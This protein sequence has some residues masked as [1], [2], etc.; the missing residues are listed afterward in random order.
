MRRH[1]LLIT[2]FLGLIAAGARAAELGHLLH[3]LEAFQ[4]QAPSTAT[5]TL[6]TAEAQRESLAQLQQE[7]ESEGEKLQR[8]LREMGAVQAQ[9]AQARGTMQQSLQSLAG[10]RLLSQV[11]LNLRRELPAIPVAEGLPE[12]LAE[13]RIQQ[14]RL[15]G[16][17]RTL[18]SA[19]VAGSA[20]ALPI[21]PLTRVLGLLEQLIE[22]GN[23]LQTRQ[24]ALSREREQLKRSLEEQLFWVPSHR[25]MDLQWLA[26]MPG[27]IGEQLA[28]TPWLETGGE[29]L[30]GLQAR[31]QLF[32]PLMLIIATLLWRR[33]W[34]IAQ[35]D[36]LNRQV[37]DP[38]RDRFWTTPLAVILVLLQA[39][40]VALALA[41]CGLALAFDARGENPSLGAA[42]LAMAEV[43]L[44][45]YATLRVL[46]PEGLAERHFHWP[47]ARVSQLRRQ[48]RVLG[49]VVLA[50]A[51]ITAFARNRPNTLEDDALG[52][53]L[54]SAAFLLTAW[55]LFRLTWSA[56][57]RRQSWS[58]G[59]LLLMLLLISMPLAL[60]LTVATGYYYTA[61]KLTERLIDSLLLLLLWQLVLA[62]MTRV[63]EV[64]AQQLALRRARRHA[65]A[66]GGET[67]DEAE[68]ALEVGEASEQSLRL[69][70]T[71]LLG[72][73][74]G[75]LYWVWA[76]L[77]GVISY[78]D[79]ITLWQLAATEETGPL[80]ISL[81]DFL[82]ALLI[83]AVAVLLGRNLPGLLEVLVLS[84]LQLAPGSA[85]AAT[86][87]LSYVIFS[88]GLIVAL[89]TLGVSWDK[90][91]WLVAALGVGLGF[92]LQEIFANF[93]SGLILLFE[94]P[95]R[96]GDVV[97]LGTQ[98]GVVKKIRIRATTISDFDRKDIIIPNKV[99]ITGDLTNW[100]L[101]DTII[102]VVVKVGV[103]YGSDLDLVRKLLLEIAREHPRVL[104]EPAPQAY[105]L[106]FGASTLDHEL[107]MHVPELD[108]RFAVI[109]AVNRRI[110]SV[111]REH[112][113]E[114]AFNQ[115]DLHL[116][117]LG[118]DE[119]RIAMRGRTGDA[120]AP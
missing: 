91:Q 70:Q 38:L 12:Q 79:N 114:I 4:Q 97:T 2:L 20:Q 107:R 39:L 109:D 6:A 21:Q 46:R 98:T 44:I 52:V 68:P 89:G 5:E 83:L 112:G 101:T 75:A 111:F 54:L 13:L 34:L 7:L 88:L 30:A 29:I 104:G 99:F 96:I 100:S 119:L 72:V 56:G 25:P 32:L 40:P 59:R 49:L 94:R 53:L 60:L 62:V 110:D 63:F 19:E 8:A 73:F 117:S 108:D 86:T 66:T 65:V 106:G 84:R 77:I 33:H 42:L 50:L 10:T 71:V 115:M 27:R 41:L 47:G 22:S 85:Y 16:Y 26:Q 82:V 76:D 28:A 116:R 93:V 48:V 18:S 9:L 23:Q 105:F 87:L 3:Q 90:L 35:V 80:P 24:M 17:R 120:P 61:L 113:V 1:W 11:L 64:A 37:G 45:F 55:Q 15:E 74:L 95:I 67:E 81:R 14:F 69:L 51:A 36:N 102:R 43:W 118:G 58:V 57:H 78:L 103:A 31:L 92:G